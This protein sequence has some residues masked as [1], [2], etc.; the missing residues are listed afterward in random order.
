MLQREVVDGEDDC[1]FVEV[2]VA[3]GR[4]EQH[5]I[6]PLGEPRALRERHELA[7]ETRGAGNQ[8]ADRGITVDGKRC[9]RGHRGNSIDLRTEH[10][11]TALLCVTWV[12]ISSRRRS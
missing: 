3:V 10:D 9:L 12:T 1:A 6:Q 11:A 7:L 2:A 8:F 4:L 5:C